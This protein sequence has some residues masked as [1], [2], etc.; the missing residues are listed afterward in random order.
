MNTHGNTCNVH[1]IKHNVLALSTNSVADEDF[2]DLSTVYVKSLV[3]TW[4]GEDD[5]DFV[6]VFKEYQELFQKASK[7]YTVL[8]RLYH[9]CFKDKKSHEKLK[10]VVK[11]TEFILSEET[12]DYQ[13]RVLGVLV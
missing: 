13:G 3:N 9:T 5:K 1:I 7:E 4:T 2:L 10:A 12:R 8:K 6:E 11:D